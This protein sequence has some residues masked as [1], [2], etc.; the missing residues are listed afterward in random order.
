MIEQKVIET[1][2]LVLRPFKMDDASE[3]QRLAG[4][5]AIAETTLNIPHPYE[6]GMAEEWISTH[7]G[8]LE[9]ESGITYAITA[10]E[11]GK[12]LGAISLMI[13]RRHE[14]AELGYWIGKPYWNKGYC[15]EA[16]KELVH[17][18]IFKIGLNRI[19]ARFFPRNGASGKVMEKIGMQYEGCYR[20]HVKARSGFEDLKTYGIIKADFKK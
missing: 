3:V 12:L 17:Y 16:A 19:F 1:E 15:T 9:D 7:K 2:R 6:D 4:D 8:N 10:K 11:N 13:N 5:R 18:G 14:H 20:Q